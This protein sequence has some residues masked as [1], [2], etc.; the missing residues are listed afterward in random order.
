MEKYFLLTYNPPPNVGITNEM[1]IKMLKKYL[2]TRS[3]EFYYNIEGGDVKKPHVHFALITNTDKES[4]R[5]SELFKGQ[6][7][8]NKFPDSKPAY[9]WM[10][11]DTKCNCISYVTKHGFI[12]KKPPLYDTEQYEERRKYYRLTEELKGMKKNKAPINAIGYQVLEWLKNKPRKYMVD[13]ETH[14]TPT[15]TILDD[16]MIDCKKDLSL[17]IYKQLRNSPL[18]FWCIAQLRMQKHPNGKS[19]YL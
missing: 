10:E 16:Y 14:S 11:Y 6:F 12:D 2:K 9:D 15:E 19:Q 1:V 17:L 13:I 5:I 8:K 4:K 18:Y 7:K 3:Y